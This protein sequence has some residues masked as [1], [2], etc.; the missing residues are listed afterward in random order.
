MGKCHFYAR[1]LHKVMGKFYLLNFEVLFCGQW[2]VDYTFLMLT[3]F[4][5]L[6]HLGFS[7]FVFDVI[8][9]DIH[10]RCNHPAFKSDRQNTTSGSGRFLL[11]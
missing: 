5:S 8:I 2:H 4:V 6:K 10:I 11:C 3:E 9:M 1:F 7:A